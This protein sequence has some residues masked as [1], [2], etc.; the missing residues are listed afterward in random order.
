MPPF[1]PPNEHVYHVVVEGGEGALADR[2]AVVVRPS[3][4]NW[5]QMRNDHIRSD[6]GV[7]VE[8]LFDFSPLGL[9]LLLLRG[10][11][12]F[13]TVTA[14]RETQEVEAVRLVTDTRLL[15]VESQP[16]FCEPVG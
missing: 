5:I 7:R 13:P 14:N 10:D 4:Q 1:R 16:P 9:Y 12:A 8:P 2:M 11:E 15:L 6:V 3:P